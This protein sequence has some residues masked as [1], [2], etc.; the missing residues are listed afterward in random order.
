M[1]AAYHG[2]AGAVTRRG[3]PCPARFA[4]MGRERSSRHPRGEEGAAGAH[5]GVARGARC[6]RHGARRGC[7]GGAWA[8]VSAAWRS[9]AR[10]LG[11]LL[12]ARGVP[13]LAAAA[14]AAWRRARAGHA[15]DAGQGQAAR[16]PRLGAG[17]CHGQG[18]CGASPS[19]R[20]TSRRWSPTSCWCRCWPSM[21]RAGGSATAGATTTARCAACARARPSSPSASP[22]TS[23]ASRRRAASRL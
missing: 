21:P 8:R 19:P 5:E 20:P 16:L 15:G 17:R 4:S 10:R 6:R 22:T 18:A 1:A 9:V 13:R 12:D 7:G 23:S 11:L 3:L 2:T 14:P